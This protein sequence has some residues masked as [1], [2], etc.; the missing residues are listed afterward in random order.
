MAVANRFKL[1][2]VQL[3]VGRSKS[4]NLSQAV[5][6]IEE[7]SSNGATVVALPECFNSPYGSKYFKEYSETIPGNTTK[8]LSEA[9]AKSKIFLIGGSIPE[10]DDGKLYN[11]CTV[12]NPEGE[13]VAQHRKIHLFD[14]DIP[15]KI[16]FKESETLSCG[17]TLT[18]F[19]TPACKIGIGICYDIRFAEIAQLYAREGCGVLLYPGAFNMT[20]GPMHWEL[21]QR[22]RALDNQLYVGAISPA[23]DTAADY[24]AWGHTTMVNPWGE[25]IGKAD[26]KQQIIY[27][28]IDLDVL[29]T[30]RQQIPV[31]VQRRTELYDVVKK[32]TTKL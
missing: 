5:K 30:V 10:V 24:I 32:P 15:G 11:T 16:T 1:A 21:L 7:A 17:N 6:L 27:A 23:R 26:E 25:V 28:D 19:D 29:K 22:A 9:A 3:L 18:T 13:I 20:T 8:V 14:I 4:D 31:T 2:L 12:F